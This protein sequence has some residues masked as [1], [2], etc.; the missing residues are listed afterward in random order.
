VSVKR[1]ASGRY[2][3]RWRQDGQN[4]QRT[5]TTK[6][7]ADL[8][9][10]EV[11]R[12]KRL[13]GLATF[14][15][16]RDTL[17]EFVAGHW[18]PDLAVDLAPA[19]RRGYANLYSAHIAPTFGAVRLRDITPRRVAAWRTSR[20]RAGAGAKALREAHTLLGGILAYAVEL[21]MVET[22]A[23]RAVR[24]RKRPKPRRAEALS[25]E[26]VERIRQ[27]LEPAWATLVAVLA[28]TGMRPGE[29]LHLRWRDIA[30]EELYVGGSFDLTASEAKTTK[31]GEVRDVRLIAPLAQDLA[32]WRMRSGRPSANAPVLPHP[33]GSTWTKNLWGN[34][35]RRTW[36]PA[37]AAAGVERGDGRSIVPYDLR[38]T[39]ASLMLAEGLSVFEVAE[40]LGHGPEQTLRT[41]GHV[42]KAYRGEPPI[43]VAQEVRRVRLALG[44][45]V[46]DVRETYARPTGVAAILG[47]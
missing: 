46:S 6:A 24:R 29:A 47:A 25:V 9:Q 23:A 4:R 16:G 5:F 14:D 10:S 1:N 32:E 34:F 2:V 44:Q 31:T 36:Q 27:H 41:Y 22:N 13:G 8:W 42:V 12:R 43:D 17:D 33:S 38:H 28:Y 11:T 21:E 7:D 40:Q 20:E 26:Q 18:A 35:G 19:T 37:V 39:A 30:G 45:P 15:G 3:V